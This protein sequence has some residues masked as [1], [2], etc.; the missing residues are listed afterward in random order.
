MDKDGQENVTTVY[1]MDI[2]AKLGVKLDELSLKTLDVIQEACRLASIKDDDIDIDHQSIY[3]FLAASRLYYG[4]FQIESGLAGDATY[5]AKPRNIR[6]LSATISIARPGSLSEIP[7]L[8]DYYQ[9]GKLKHIHPQF[10]EILRDTA[11]V[12]I[13]QESI[14]EICQ[15]IYGLSPQDADEVRRAISKK[16]ARGYC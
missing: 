12:I 4:C 3:D 8:V 9:T 13:Y 5:K 7:T 16:K 1:D 11:N 14:N 2:V 6:Q 15:R 10:D